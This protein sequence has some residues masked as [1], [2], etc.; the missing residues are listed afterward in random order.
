MKVLFYLLLFVCLRAIA[1]PNDCA[2]A[3]PGC[4]TPAFAIAPNNPST[5]IVD[6]SSGSIS[7]P[8]LNPNPVPGNSG[9]LLS[10]ETSSTFI[11][12]SVV[13]DGTLEWSIIG[14]SGGCFDWIM[15]PYTANSCT[16]IINNQLYAYNGGTLKIYGVN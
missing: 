3:V 9:C 10:G 15:W 4:T 11:S 14:A 7:N 12:I 16:Q 13:S 6:F 5:N 1:Q 2:D 8:A